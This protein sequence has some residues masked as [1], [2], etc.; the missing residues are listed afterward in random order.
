MCTNYVLF[1]FSDTVATIDAISHV[2]SKIFAEGEQGKI[3]KEIRHYDSDFNLARFIRNLERNVIPSVLK[4]YADGNLKTLRKFMT[5]AAFAQASANLE[6]RKFVGIEYFCKV[7]DIKHVELVNTQAKEF[8]KST[9]PWIS[10]G[11]TAR[12]KT[13]SYY[14]FECRAIY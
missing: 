9:T 1:M 2:G 10:V 11:E 6:Q 14:I 12:Y 5:I 13:K 8:V 4:A 7:L 3:L